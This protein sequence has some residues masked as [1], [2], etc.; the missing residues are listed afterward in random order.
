M[1][2]VNHKNTKAL[3]RSVVFIGNFEHFTS[4]SSVSIADFKKFFN[5]FNY[6]YLQSANVYY[7]TATG[8]EH[9]TT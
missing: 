8:L 6:I 3:H 5:W 7:I 9:R 2:K 4:F 1:F